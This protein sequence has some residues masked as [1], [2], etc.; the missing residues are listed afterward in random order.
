MPDHAV[1]GDGQMAWPLF[2]QPRKARLAVEP[3]GSGP[4]RGA[5]A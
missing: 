3:G 1:A 2:R 5:I 4:N